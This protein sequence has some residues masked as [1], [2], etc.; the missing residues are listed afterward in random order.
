[1]SDLGLHIVA[2]D[3]TYRELLVLNRLN[4]PSLKISEAVRMSCSIP[5]FFTPVKWLG[6]G[7]YATGI[8]RIVV[9]GG[10]ICNT[11]S[12]IFDERGE[13]HETVLFAFRDE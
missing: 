4:T 2:C 11:P 6:T 5:I 7:K 9:D 8:E 12:F 13:F 1:M 10:L 3:L